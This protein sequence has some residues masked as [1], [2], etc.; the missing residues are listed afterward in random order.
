[1]AW[2][3]ME[4]HV[5]IEGL[6]LHILFNYLVLASKACKRDFSHTQIIYLKIASILIIIISM[7]QEV[8]SIAVSL[9]VSL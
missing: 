3:Q 8:D 9:L 7:Q 6:P 2:L 5:Y 4:S 1:M